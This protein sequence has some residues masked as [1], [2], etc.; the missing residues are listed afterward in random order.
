MSAPSR[1]KTGFASLGD[2]EDKFGFEDGVLYEPEY[3]GRILLPNGRIDGLRDFDLD[4]EGDGAAISFD[5]L[6]IRAELAAFRADPVYGPIAATL[7]KEGLAV[8]RYGAV[9]YTS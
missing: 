8:L 3:P 4:V 2:L 7:E 6:D 1:V 5:G 9:A